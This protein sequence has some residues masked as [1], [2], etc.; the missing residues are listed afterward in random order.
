MQFLVDIGVNSIACQSNVSIRDRAFNYGDGC[1]TTMYAYN[2]K[3][4]LFARHLQRL[5]RDTAKLGIQIDIRAIKHK[6]LE[7]L[8]SCENIDD[9]ALVI[10]I[11]ISRGVGGRGY[12]LPEHATTSVVITINHTA[13]YNPKQAPHPHH[14][15]LCSFPLASQPILAGIKH[16]NR[17]E[18][19]MAKREL[20]TL[21]GTHDLLFKDQQDRLIEATAANIFIKLDGKWL[22]PCLTESG[23]AGVMRE[24]I[25]AYFEQLNIPYSICHITQSD[26]ENAESVFLCNALK[27]I[28]P[29]TSFEGQQTIHFDPTPATNI[30]TGVYDSTWDN[31]HTGR[32]YTP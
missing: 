3:V 20:A 32:N 15:Q 10:K 29:V 28:V 13:C 4:S 26:L 16:L 6:V 5:S 9:V 8:S 18:Q 14:I 19:I 21:T 17:L 27:F 24:A 30:A 2:R 31:E 25:I 1:F 22:S 11:H 12:E 23:V 7:T